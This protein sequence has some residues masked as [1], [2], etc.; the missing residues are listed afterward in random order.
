[1]FVEQQPWSSPGRSPVGI[2]D[3]D[4]RTPNGGDIPNVPEFAGRGMVRQP[5]CQRPDDGNRALGYAPACFV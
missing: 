4:F 3:K 5:D 2:V 1:M